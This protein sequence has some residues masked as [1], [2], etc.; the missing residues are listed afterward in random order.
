MAAGLIERALAK[1]ARGRPSHQYSLTEKGLRNTGSNFADL[2]LALWKEV[3]QIKDP[4]VRSG[5]L[6]RIARTMAMMYGGE[7]RGESTEERMA[8]VGRLLGERNV[9]V[10]VDRSGQLPVLT[11]LACPYPTLAEQ[12]RGICSVEKILFSELVGEKVRLTECRLDGKSNCC[13][14]EVN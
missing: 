11:A 1:A 4:E 12:D 10:T 6:A 7:V 13:R 2:A 9:P 14:F 3:R 5:L 8:A